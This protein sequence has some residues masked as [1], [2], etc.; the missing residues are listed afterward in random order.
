M[1]MC[2]INFFIY[3]KQQKKINI[4]GQ[5]ARVGIFLVKINFE[6]KLI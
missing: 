4:Y 1:N 3:L 2:R 5:N 6:K